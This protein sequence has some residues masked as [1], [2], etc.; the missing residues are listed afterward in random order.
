MTLLIS[1]HPVPLR[2]AEGG[3]VRIGD[4]RI[5]LDSVVYD[6]KN[7]ATAEQIAFDFPTLD[8]ADIHAVIAWYLRHRGEVEQYLIDQQQ[9]AAEVRKQIEPIVA[10]GDIRT[11]LLAR[12]AARKNNDASAHGG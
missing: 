1:D 9:Q 11:R 6:Y 8:L 7:G 3:V 10:S 4:S 12:R 5:S 2:T